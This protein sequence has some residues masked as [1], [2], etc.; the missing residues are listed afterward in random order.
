MDTTSSIASSITTVKVNAAVTGLPT[1]VDAV[2]DK[3]K[4]TLT[5]DLPTGRV[6][7]HYDSMMHHSDEIDA[8]KNY[9]I[10]EDGKLRKMVLTTSGGKY[11]GVHL[12]SSGSGYEAR[13]SNSQVI[14]EH[15]SAREAA[16]ARAQYKQS[17]DSKKSRKKARRDSD[18]DDDDEEDLPAVASS[19]NKKKAHAMA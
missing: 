3:T 5:M 8:L 17:Q 1:G 18:D 16:I 15:D 13:V 2:V 4:K 12:K 7:V 11:A 9:F 14:S 10:E 6:V 19:K